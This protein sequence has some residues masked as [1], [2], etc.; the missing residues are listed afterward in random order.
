VRDAHAA[1]EEFDMARPPAAQSPRL[2]GDAV[3]IVGRQDRTDAIVDDQNA[4]IGVDVEFAHVRLDR[5]SPFLAARAAKVSGLTEPPDAGAAALGGVA[6]R[7]YVHS[8]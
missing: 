4:E 7:G 6:Q 8:D 1:E 2:V 3:K 5:A